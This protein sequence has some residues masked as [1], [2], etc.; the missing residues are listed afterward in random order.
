[1]RARHM[2]HERDR[3][4][5]TPRQPS[6]AE[7]RDPEQM[8]AG[9]EEQRRPDDRDQHGLA[10]VGLQDRAG[11]WS[12]RSSARPRMLPARP[13]AAPP[14]EN[15]QAARMTKAGLTNSE[16][17]MPMPASMIQRR[18]PLTSAPE[19]QRGA[20]RAPWRRRRAR[21]QCAA[22]A[23]RRG[24]DDRDHHREGRRGSSIWRL[25]KWKVGRPRRSATGGLPPCRARCRRRSS[26]A[27]A[28][29]SQVDGP[30]PIGERALLDA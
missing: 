12:R 25:T 6:A 9:H 10:D 30:P 13:C 5:N 8:Q 23:R 15:S 29:S 1:M 2:R 24:S 7:A 22:R 14:S 21:A 26:D 11:R 18:A 28:G 20:R 27:E 4:A 19:E 3:R 16:G 17:W